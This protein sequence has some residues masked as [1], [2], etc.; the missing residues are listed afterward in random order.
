VL[1]VGISMGFSQGK[2][3]FYGKQS[4]KMRLLFEI[5]HTKKV[6]DSGAGAGV[7]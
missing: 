7:C 6:V 2:R 1:I 5:A 4:I 3:Y